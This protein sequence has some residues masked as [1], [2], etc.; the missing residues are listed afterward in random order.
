LGQLHG[1][2]VSKSLCCLAP[3]LFALPS[4]LADEPLSD[5]RR[6]AS[7][8]LDLRPSRLLRDDAAPD[9][10]CLRQLR[11]SAVA[12]VAAPQLKTVPAKL[13]EHSSLEARLHQPS[14][15][16]FGTG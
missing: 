12:C 9:V 14:G 15:H 6:V 8:V 4:E 13:H 1:E 10:S 7:F 2:A 5:A 11:P 16:F 3:R